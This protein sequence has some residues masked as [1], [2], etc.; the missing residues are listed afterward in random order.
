[1]N[2]NAHRASVTWRGGGLAI[3]VVIGIALQEAFFAPAAGPTES[4]AIRG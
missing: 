1:M 2:G 3:L 4:K